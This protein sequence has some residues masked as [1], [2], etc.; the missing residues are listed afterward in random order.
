MTIVYQ[1]TPITF[2]KACNIIYHEKYNKI[3]LHFIIIVK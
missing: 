2:N 3:I 1:K